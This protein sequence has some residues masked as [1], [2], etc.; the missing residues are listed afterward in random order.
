MHVPRSERNVT[1]PRQ[2][3]GSLIVAILLVEVVERLCGCAVQL[4]DPRVELDP[5]AGQAAA[6]FNT[7]LEHCH[8]QST[9]SYLV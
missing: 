9:A 3:V 4:P 5:V 7:G 1:W 6:G 8:V 2:R